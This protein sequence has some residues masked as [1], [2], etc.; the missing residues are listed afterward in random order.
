MRIVFRST[1]RARGQTYASAT[2]RPS[3]RPAS[4][5]RR[6]PPAAGGPVF[7]VGERREADGMLRLILR[8]DLDLSVAESLSA[9]LAELKA[10]GR[11]VRL[12]LSQLAFI[13][14]SGLQ[15]LIV[16]LIDARS[17]GW[18]LEVASEISPTVERAARVVGIA[19]ILWPDD[20]PDPRSGAAQPATRSNELG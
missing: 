4:E 17:V 8:G 19:Q 18:R 16:A 14:S 1:D 5:V 6:R 2:A 3:A 15:A 12:D 20:R 10:T 13:D 11:P 9:R 7:D